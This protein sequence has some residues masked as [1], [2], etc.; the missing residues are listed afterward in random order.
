M[1]DADMYASV[2]CDVKIL[3]GQEDRWIPWEKMESLVNKMGH[4]VREFIAIP[5]AGHLIMID[6][7][8]RVALE[9]LS[10]LS[11]NH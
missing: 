9:V 4:R 3:W 2:R 11:Q 8:E 10:W 5:E 7:P 6:Q 1:L